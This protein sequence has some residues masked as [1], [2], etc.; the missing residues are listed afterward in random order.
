MLSLIE[1]WKANVE[2]LYYLVLASL[3]RKQPVDIY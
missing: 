3:N 1:I 2:I